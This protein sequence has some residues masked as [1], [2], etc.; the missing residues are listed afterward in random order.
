MSSLEK[1]R[2]VINKNSPKK[3]I[4]LDRL[5]YLKKYYL[6]RYRFYMLKLYD[7]GYI[8]DPTVFNNSEMYFNVLD[9]D[10]KPMYDSLGRIILSS[11][12][13]AFSMLKANTE[14]KDFLSL[15]YPV[16]IYREYSNDLDIFYETFR[17]VLNLKLVYQGGRIIA[18]QEINLSRG[19]LM[20]FVS[21]EET[22]YTE[23]ILPELWVLCMKALAIPE[24]EW[25]N[26]GNF[27]KGFTHEEELHFMKLIFSG[28]TVLDG[29]NSSKLLSWLETHKWGKAT[30]NTSI[31]GLM[32]YI[33]SEY[34]T[35]VLDIIENKL[36]TLDLNNVVSI[37]DE[38]IYIKKPIEN[39][40]VPISH[41]CV[42]SGI[43]G[44][45]DILVDDIPFQGYT[46]EAYPVSYLDEE[47]IYYVG[48]PIEVSIS[49]VKYLAYDR[50]Q[51]KIDSD[52]F[53]SSIRSFDFEDEDSFLPNP[54]PKGSLEYQIYG[55]YIDAMRGKETTLKTSSG[56]KNI[57]KAI[58]K[59]G[60]N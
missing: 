18:K 16:L 36:S 33:Y 27:V 40:H 44:Y 21:P 15:L 37:S 12:R 9:L 50:E 20:Y 45:D 53:F 59:L 48:V 8:S 58:S 1:V 7:K 52:T 47:G 22:L 46:G 30:L 35:E 13:V 24:S 5:M 38:Y 11:E 60:G 3:Q 39:Y 55:V 10:I 49:G 54:Y 19:N 4:N 43:N 42:M 25:Y 32:G 26:D 14:Q 51:V 56:C 23:N 31:T 17:K 28:E 6:S 2:E 57:I 29:Y 34:A 41:F